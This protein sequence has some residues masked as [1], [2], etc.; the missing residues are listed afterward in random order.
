[1]ITENSMIVHKPP[2]ENAKAFLDNSSVHELFPLSIIIQR[3]GVLPAEYTGLF[4][5]SGFKLT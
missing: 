2:Q 3:K 5:L 4:L 1:M